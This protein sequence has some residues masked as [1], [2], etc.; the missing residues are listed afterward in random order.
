MS[1][2]VLATILLPS[3]FKKELSNLA[4]LWFLERDRDEMQ[5]W[6]CTL[7]MLLFPLLPSQPE[8]GKGILSEI[9]D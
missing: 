5:A 6:G 9:W 8:E 2:L 3:M 4:Y 7:A 1:V